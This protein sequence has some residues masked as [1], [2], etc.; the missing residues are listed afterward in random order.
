MHRLAAYI[1]RQFGVADSAARLHHFAAALRLKVAP[2]VHAHVGFRQVFAVQSAAGHAVRHVRTE[3]AVGGTCVHVGTACP[4]AQRVDV[5]GGI[6]GTQVGCLGVGLADDEPSVV[7]DVLA[8]GR[9]LFID[10]TGNG[11]QFRLLVGHR[12]AFEDAVVTAPHLLG[13]IVRKVLVLLVRVITEPQ[14]FSG[15]TIHGG[16]YLRLRDG[17]VGLGDDGAKAVTDEHFCRHASG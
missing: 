15:D 9:V 11:A 10:G 13:L 2:D 7:Q 16:A 6:D 12:A 4:V 8:V 1:R 3:F 14:S 17:D 5:G